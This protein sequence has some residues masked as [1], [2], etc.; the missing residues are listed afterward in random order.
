MISS[1][2]AKVGDLVRQALSAHSKQDLSSAKRL[3][4][5]ALEADPFCV[6]ALVWLGTIDAQEKNYQRAEELFVRA[7]SLTESDADLFLNYASMLF[8]LDEH[9]RAADYFARGIHIRPSPIGLTNLAICLNKLGN[10]EEALRYAE[11]LTKLYPHHAAGWCIKA[12]SLALLARKTEALESYR[13]AIHADPESVRAWVNC[14]IVLFELKRYNEALAHF[15]QA[16]VLDASNAEAWNNKGTAL[17]ELARH[18][19]AIDC[20]DRAISLAPDHALAWSNRG[21][22]LGSLQRS[23]QA[24]RSFEKSIA[25]DPVNA[26]AHYQRALLKLQ[27]KDFLDG[28][29]EYRWRWKTEKFD[30]PRLKTGLPLCESL[31]E[32]DRLILWAE[33]GLGDEVFYSGLLP[34]IVKRH[35]NLTL[36][37]DVRLHNIYRRS[38]PGIKLIDRSTAFEARWDE[39]FDCHAPIGDLGRLLEVT[40]RDLRISAKPYLTPSSAKVESL[41]SELTS[42]GT[43]FTCGLS[44]KSANPNFGAW[45]SLNMQNLYPLLSG[46]PSDYVSLQ[47]GAGPGEL[48]DARKLV[49]NRMRTLPGLDLFN[50]IESLLAL[51]EA[52]DVVVTSSNITAH[53]AGSVGKPTAVLVPFS[54]G[55][56]WYWHVEDA[57]SLWYPT[58]KIFRQASSGDWSEA[59]DS[60]GEWLC[61]IDSKSLER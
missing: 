49:G 41:R 35:S 12:D 34:K 23:E 22:A 2:A 25:L 39:D 7:L 40:E 10:V 31:S 24:F 50:D 48:N 20:Y 21:A 4:L 59:I 26:D 15:D 57:M 36:V 56:I 13:L 1:G 19:E 44:W 17:N 60:V 16:I 3:Y 47:Y 9:K 53:L 33:Q 8:E 30:S 5:E 58:V 52:C 28:F 32:H 18:E 55:R 54:K 46:C 14:G 42:S 37:A 45:K 38:F 27:H 11:I 51:V 43:N 6:A 61:A 29:R